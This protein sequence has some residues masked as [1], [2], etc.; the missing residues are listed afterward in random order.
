MSVRVY[1]AIVWIEQGLVGRGS[2]GGWVPLLWL[3]WSGVSA[4]VGSSVGG[5]CAVGFVGASLVEG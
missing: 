2:A 4:V 1:V 3:E 5:G